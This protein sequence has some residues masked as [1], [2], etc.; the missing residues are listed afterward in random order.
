MITKHYS[1]TLTSDWAKL[2][3]PVFFSEFAFVNRNTND[4]LIKYNDETVYETV[5][6]NE[7]YYKSPRAI[8]QQYK[9]E[10]YLKGTPA[11]ALVVEIVA[12]KF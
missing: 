12:E 3:I 2:D 6:A 7:A 8:G 10:V 9:D 11:D 4:V 5:R 1:V